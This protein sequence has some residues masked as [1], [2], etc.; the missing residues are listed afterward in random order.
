MAQWVVVGPMNF[1]TANGLA[2]VGQG[3]PMQIVA[4]DFLQIISYI[5]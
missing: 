1:T 3:L 4:F 2:R 5:L